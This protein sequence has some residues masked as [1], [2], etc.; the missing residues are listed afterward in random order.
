MAM[1]RAAIRRVLV[2]QLQE[3]KGEV[4]D[5]V[6]DSVRL[7]E[8]LGLDSID[9]VT[10]VINIQSRFGVELKSEELERVVTVGNLL[11]LLLV[12]LSPARAAA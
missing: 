4:F 8:G 11:D 3:D 12:K 2:E 1:D 10:L 6:D 9:V 7:R 5:N